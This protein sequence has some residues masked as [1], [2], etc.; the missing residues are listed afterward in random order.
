MSKSKGPKKI[1]RNIRY[2]TQPILQIL[3]LYQ[4]QKVSLKMVELIKLYQPLNS[5]GI[6]YVE[7]IIQIKI[8]FL[9]KF[10]RK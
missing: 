4:D 5:S 9:A 2:S 8:V 6:N 10:T 7:N 3:G 1:L